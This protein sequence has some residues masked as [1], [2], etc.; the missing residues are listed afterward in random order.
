MWLH[1]PG[2]SIKKTMKESHWPR[3]KKIIKIVITKY[4]LLLEFFILIMLEVLN[5]SKTK[6]NFIF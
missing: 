1:L 5:S 2:V 4:V 6:K 3:E